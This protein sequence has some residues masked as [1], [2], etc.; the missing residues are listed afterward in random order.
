MVGNALDE[1]DER[2]RQVRGDT[3]LI[4]L[5]AHHEE[6]TFALPTVSTGTAWLRA[7]DTIAPSVEERPYDGGESYP[8]QG[9]TLAAFVLRTAPRRRSSDGLGEPIVP[10]SLS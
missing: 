1:V 2:G 4:L 5:N 9:R 6:V 10:A 3:V 7:L 8:L